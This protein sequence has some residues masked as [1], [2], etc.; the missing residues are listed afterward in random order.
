MA[1]NIFRCCVPVLWFFAGLAN[2]QVIGWIE[3]IEGGW[4][5]VS[6]VRSGH[7]QSVRPYMPVQLGDE[8]HLAGAKN[9]VV[10]MLA[11][12]RSQRITFKQTPFKLEPGGATPTIHGN[13]LKWVSGIFG[14]KDSDSSRLRLTSMTSRGVAAGGL[15]VPYMSKWFYVVAK[16]RPY[17]FSWSG[18]TPP[19]QLR[20]TRLSDG[21]AA[22]A[23]N[24]IEGRG[25]LTSILDMKAG[26]YLFEVIDAT[27]T[28]YQ[29]QLR[30]VPINKLPIFPDSLQSVPKETADLIFASWL[31]RADSGVWVV[32]AM[33]QLHEL[34]DSSST[35]KAVLKKVE[36]GAMLDE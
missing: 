10:L 13:I 16:T 35:A 25:I 26:D 11:D 30:A 17:Y 23:V 21:E 19:F 14:D 7:N 22:F 29:D 6:L 2:A 36:Q 1:R 28:T 4:H 31:A 33:Q 32:E 5:S 18:G 27:Q 34:S 3:T 12:G 15:T 20:I 8:I 24:D 9:V